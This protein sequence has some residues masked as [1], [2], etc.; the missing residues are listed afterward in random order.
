MH[1][2][3][4]YP[5]DADDVALDERIWCP[6][7]VCD[8]VAR[9]AARGVLDEHTVSHL[10]DM[11]ALANELADLIVLDVRELSLDDGGAELLRAVA[12]RADAA[13]GWLTVES[14]PDPPTHWRTDEYANR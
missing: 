4:R 8:G 1:L 2:D 9:I 10:E 3:R 13:G 5:A 12:R 11:V 14:T 6:L 7:L